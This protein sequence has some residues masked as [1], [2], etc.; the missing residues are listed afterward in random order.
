MTAVDSQQ[1]TQRDIAEAVFRQRL[2][3]YFDSLP[4]ALLAVGVNSALLTVVLWDPQRR[5]GLGTWFAAMLLLVLL[6]GIG[7]YRFRRSGPAVAQ[8]RRW[9]RDILAGA[10]LS[11]FLWGAGGYLLFDS[12][13]DFGQLLLIVIIA[14]TCAGGIVSNAAFAGA[15][16][17]FLVLTLPPLALRM[18]TAGGEGGLLLSLVVLMFLAFMSGL[19]L[20]A[21]RT[22]VGGIR[23]GHLQARAERTV[24]RQALYDDLTGLPNRRLLRDRLQQV[25]AR[26]QRDGGHAAL[27]FLDLDHFKR[28]NDSLGHSVGDLLLVAVADRLR[29]LLR[30]SDTAA[31]L[32]GDEFVALLGELQGDRAQVLSVIRRRGEELLQG[33]ERPFRVRGNEVHVS[34]SIGVSVLP[35]ESD[36][37]DNLLR[38]AD[39][40][41]YQAKEQGR[42]TLRFFVR[43]MQQALARR[44]A[45]EQQLRA[46]LDSR[47]GLELHLQPQ[48]DSHLHI[49]GAETLLRWCHDGQY[50]APGD[51]IPIAEDCGLI[52]RLGDWVLDEACRLGAALLPRVVAEDFSLA[53]NVSPR[54][55]RQKGFPGKVLAALQRH[56]VPARLI[57]LELTEGVIV[58]DVEETA[59]RMRELRRHGLRFSV[60]DFGTG[61]SSLRYLKSLPLD[62]LK[63]DQSFVRDVL[64]DRDSASIV[65]LIITMARSLELNVIAEGV[66]TRAIHEFLARA[67]CVQFQ[68]FLYSRP[69]DFDSFCALCEQPP[70]ADATNPERTRV[71]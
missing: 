41:M 36:N 23:A 6:R 64:T 56:G 43:D 34:A 48:Y 52:Y 27:L 71:P 31:R 47:V 65:R 35:G 70:V 40:A 7:L 38:H 68:G 54:Q 69:L 15:S 9:Y 59:S 16:I 55:F 58:E 61:Y 62:T 18:L 10:L 4:T 60:D 45:V 29:T 33:I 46:A 13:P 21:S 42:N 3:L 2:Q 39:T 14:G 19:A 51:F 8:P 25:I 17:G 50:V 28:V 12:R 66:E 67:G 11:G 49:C 1:E 37:V 26:T 5:P 53:V 30:E 63:I 32:G 20:R 22:L 57:D 44:L 24:E